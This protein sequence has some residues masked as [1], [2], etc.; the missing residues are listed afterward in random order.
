LLAADK[1]PNFVRLD[2]ANVHLAHGHF[3]EPFA[4]FPGFNYRVD[5]R[6]PVKLGEPFN[7]ANAVA[8]QEHPERKDSLVSRK[9]APVNGPGR[10]V[11]ERLAARIA[12][13]AARTDPV[14]TEATHS[15]FAE[16][17]LHDDPRFLF[18]ADRLE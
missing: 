17:T 12:A 5:D 1:P 3:Q 7:R 16:W 13:I 18:A 15:T 11:G 10:F 14:P 4:G 6:I 2:I 9:P 8:L